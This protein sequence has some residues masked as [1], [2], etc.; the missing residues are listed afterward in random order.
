MTNEMP[1]RRQARIR[2]GMGVHAIRSDVRH[3]QLPAGTVTSK[4][5]HPD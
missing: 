4:N 5:P 1:Y 3:R 2:K